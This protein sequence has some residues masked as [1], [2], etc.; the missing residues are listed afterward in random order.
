MTD[1]EVSWMCPRKIEELL[2]NSKKSKILQF[3]D[4]AGRQLAHSN[5]IR[6]SVHIVLGLYHLSYPTQKRSRCP[7]QELSYL[8]VLRSIWSDFRPLM[9]NK[10]PFDLTA[11]YV[12]YLVDDEW[13]IPKRFSPSH[14]E[15]TKTNVSTQMDEDE[16]EQ[17]LP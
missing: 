5:L 17:W 2:C 13:S 16:W 7:L 14:Y 10:R 1:L 8:D 11:Q 6:P 12:G 15:S 3:I 9:E 4:Q